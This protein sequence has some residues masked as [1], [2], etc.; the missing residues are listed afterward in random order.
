[1]LRSAAQHA[2]HQTAAEENVERPLVNAKRWADRVVTRHKRVI[3]S[4]WLLVRLSCVAFGTVAASFN[5]T[6]YRSGVSSITQTANCPITRVGSPPFSPPAPYPETAPPGTFWYG[7]EGLWTMLRVDGTWQRLPH[8]ANGFRQKVFWWHPGFDGRTEQ[9]P[10]LTVMGR[11][12]N[13]EGSFTR[14]PPATNAS[15]AGFGGWTILTGIDVPTTGCWELT[16]S[17][18]GN[19]LTFVVSI[20]P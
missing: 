6:A 4:R 5:V 12:L 2:L 19:T 20:A 7:T 1:V 17:Y 9:K 18:R 14:L 16:G 13:G 15:N 8:N 11:R 10:E 3:M